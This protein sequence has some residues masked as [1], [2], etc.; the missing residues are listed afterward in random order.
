MNLKLRSQLTDTLLMIEP[1]QF[2]FNEEAFATNSFQHEPENDEISMIQTLALAEF[3][4]FVSKLT[5]IGVDV[6]VFR[7]SLDSFTP[8]SIFP[9]N[10]ISTHESG[11]LYTYPMAVPNRRNERKTHIIQDLIKK[12]G[13]THNDLSSWENETPPRYLEGTGGMILDRINRICY[14]ATSPRAHLSALEEFGEMANFEIVT[15]DA[16]GRNGEVIYHTNV[17]LSVGET[18]V[19]V[20]VETIKPTDRERVLASFK[21]TGKEVI[22]FTNDQIYSDFAGNMLQIKNTKGESI[23]VLSDRIYQRLSPMQRA[24][25][26][27]HNNHLLPIDIQTIEKIGGGSVRCMLAEIFKP[28]N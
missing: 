7:D 1:V 19:C 23:L 21:S 28:I 9:N 4:A 5:E 18:F 25:L 10:W 3:K 20:G 8:D 13:F 12:Y 15:F 6:L 2:G 11:S 22:E 16:Y 17:M 26:E 24:Q 14:A 27:K